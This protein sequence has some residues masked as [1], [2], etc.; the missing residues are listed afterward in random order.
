MLIDDD[1]GGRN[2]CK[3]EDKFPSTYR[4]VSVIMGLFFDS[5]SLDMVMIVK[6]ERPMY[7]V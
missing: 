7:S 4:A 3:R 6:R 5:L 1:V 2:E